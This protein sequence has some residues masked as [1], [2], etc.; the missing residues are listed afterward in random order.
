MINNLDLPKNSKLKISTCG[1]SQA[2][3]KYYLKN[4]YKNYKVGHY[5]ESDFIIMTNRVI[6]KEKVKG[7]LLIVLKNLKVK[8]FT[9]SHVM[10][11]FYQ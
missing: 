9:K 1:V 7:N 3:P 5:K 11:Q 8:I 4:G 6:L 10:E 2:V